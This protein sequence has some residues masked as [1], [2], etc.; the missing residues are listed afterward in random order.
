M[1]RDALTILASLLP[2]RDRVSDLLCF[3]RK[4]HPA[5]CVNHRLEIRKRFLQFGNSPERQRNLH[6]VPVSADRWDFE[7]VH[8]LDLLEPVFRIFIE[9]LL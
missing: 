2:G 6:R 5:L 8:V 1:S 4:N 3:R 9:D 7:Y